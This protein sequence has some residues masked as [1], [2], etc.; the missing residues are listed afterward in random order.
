MHRHAK[1]TPLGRAEMVRR[2]VVVACGVKEVAAGFGV[3]ERTVRKWVKRSR[4][5]EAT[6][7]EDHSS[8]PKASPRRL[9][10]ETQKTIVELRRQR[11]T[12]ARIAA[13][14]GLSRATLSRYWG[15]AGLNRAA[16][17]EPVVP[18]IRYEKAR[19]RELL[20]LDSKKLGCI[21]RPGHRV[22]GSR[23]VRARGKSGW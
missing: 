22:T 3:C 20:H 13:H 19:P 6:A 16:N 1:L 10:V 9:N 8:R 14:L 4:Y 23:Q 7:L 15:R 5:H 18:G 12:G 21:Q 2:V 17:P 11:W